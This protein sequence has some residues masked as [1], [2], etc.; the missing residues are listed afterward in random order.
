MQYI[1]IKVSAETRETL[2]KY[3]EEKKTKY[4]NQKYF[5]K[6]KDKAKTTTKKTQQEQIKI[7]K[8]RNR[9]IG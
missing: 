4:S 5:Q 8:K 2:A 7:K 1:I 6:T 3:L 9:F